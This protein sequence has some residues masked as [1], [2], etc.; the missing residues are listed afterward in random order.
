VQGGVR[1]EVAVKTCRDSLS[2]DQK[3]KFLQEASTMKH[4]NHPNIVQFIGI[5][6]NASEILIVMEYLPG[7]VIL[8]CR[9]ISLI[10]CVLHCMVD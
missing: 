6:S 2:D 8:N 3:A 7:T 5:C 4:Y 10:V 9:F 1:R